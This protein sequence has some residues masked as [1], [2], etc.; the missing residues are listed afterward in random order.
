MALDVQEREV[1]LQVVPALQ[2]SVQVEPSPLNRPEDEGHHSES[3]SRHEWAH[4]VKRGRLNAQV[5]KLEIGR[6]A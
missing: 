6:E 1:S 4:W 2:S 5:S 3:L